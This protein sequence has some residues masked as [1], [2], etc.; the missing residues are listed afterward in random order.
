MDYDYSYNS[1]NKDYTGTYQVTG[2]KMTMNLKESKYNAS[3]KKDVPIANGETISPVYTMK[4]EDGEMTLTLISGTPM[5][6]YQKVGETV[7]YDKF[8]FD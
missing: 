6:K 4:L 1:V 7:K 5:S 8:M 2:D 3:L